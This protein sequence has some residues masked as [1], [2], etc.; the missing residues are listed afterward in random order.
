MISS[1]VKSKLV[2]REEVVKLDVWGSQHNAAAVALHRAACRLPADTRHAG[3]SH[4]FYMHEIQ[5]GTRSNYP[6][7][8]LENARIRFSANSPDNNSAALLT[9]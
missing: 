7:P 9:L 6:S 4:F 8:L 3:G 5:R 2:N 1:A